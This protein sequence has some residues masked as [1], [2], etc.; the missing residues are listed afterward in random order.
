M[1]L[2]ER[3]ENVYQELR[4]RGKVHTRHDFAVMM[5]ASD[6][7]VSRAFKSD[8]RYLT[9]SIVKR[10]EALLSGE[11][12]PSP[13]KDPEQT[14]GTADAIFIPKETAKLY[15]N[16]SESIRILSETIAKMQ[17]VTFARPDM[18]RN[19]DKKG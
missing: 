17:G 5:D 6:T 2:L 15:T 1:D 3:L 12:A 19:E 14:A 4:N 9:P 8:P 13:S 18:V 16:M 7:T 11:P 10:A